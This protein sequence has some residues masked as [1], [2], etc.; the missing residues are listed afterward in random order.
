METVNG[1][2]ALRRADAGARQYNGTVVLQGNG[3][4][5]I[6]LNDVLPRLDQAGYNM[7][8]YYISSVEMFNLLDP[9]E[10]ERIFPERLTFESMGITDFTLPTMYRWVRST[11]GLDHTL[12]SFRRRHYLGSGSAEK[13][14]EEAG[15]HAAGQWE[16]ISS[17]ARKFEGARSAS[18]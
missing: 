8:I 16:A 14:L 10:R 6:F 12:H 11:A 2:Y 13:V 4:A 7:N 18:A 3:V 15:I 1:V 5:T 9:A 17:F